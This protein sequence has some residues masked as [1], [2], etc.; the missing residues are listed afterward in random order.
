MVRVPVFS[1]MKYIYNTTCNTIFDK[2]GPS[3]WLS[4]REM[5]QAAPDK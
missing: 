3:D 5:T 1:F 2:T 4:L